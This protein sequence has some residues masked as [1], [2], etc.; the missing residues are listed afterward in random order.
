MN[1]TRGDG[2]HMPK[3]AFN[4]Q[5]EPYQ[6]VPQW[7]M[8][9]ALNLGEYP[10]EKLILDAPLRKSRAQNFGTLLSLNILKNSPNFKLLLQT[11]LRN[12][13]VYDSIRLSR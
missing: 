9:E 1:K 13:L 12:R 4:Q 7:Q 3:G 6:S 2:I 10:L 5:Y 8:P 11:F